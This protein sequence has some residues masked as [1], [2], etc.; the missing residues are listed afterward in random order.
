MLWIVGGMGAALALGAVLKRVLSNV[1][2][3]MEKPQLD[4]CRGF[5][6][7]NVLC[8]NMGMTTAY[9][10]RGASGYLLVDTGF[11]GDYDK[12]RAGLAH[13][14]IELSE[15]KAILLTHGHDD[16]A[17]FAARLLEETGARLIVHQD[18]LPLLRGEQSTPQGVRFL[19]ARV[20][21]LSIVYTLLTRRDFAYP[22][23][24]PADDDFVLSGDDD[25]ILHSLGFDAE[26][27]ATPGHT[28]GS[29]SV[30][31]PEG[32]VLCG[33]AV[34]TFLPYSG[35]QLRPI[36]VAD[37]EAVFASWRK[38]L[39]SGARVIYPAH[40]QPLTA[41]RLA[42]TLQAFRPQ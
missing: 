33:D 2:A 32:E 30:V 22:P 16:H 28:S 21:A 27:I 8:V 35:A 42:A 39:D 14:G 4:I 41:E 29:I 15:I 6:S 5:E 18:A 3:E 20:F 11:P 37:I 9:L 34:M 31:T 36:F 7:E 19:N 38:I 1:I 25:H 13:L 26:V 12:F 10:L 40:G 17:G 24:T 23:V